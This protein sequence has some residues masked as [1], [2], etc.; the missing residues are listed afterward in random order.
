MSSIR[1]I[2]LAKRPRENI[3]PGETFRTEN[4]PA[5]KESELKDGEV[6]YEALYLSIDPTMRG[7]LN[8]KIS[9]SNLTQSLDA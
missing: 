6:I 1:R 4:V 3:V 2:V 9:K 5:P 8:G 7:W